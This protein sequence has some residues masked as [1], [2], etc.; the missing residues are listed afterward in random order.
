M[1]ALTA[2]E[3]EGRGRVLNE[4]RDWRLLYVL[5]GV[6]AFVALG[7]MLLDIGLAMV[8][9]WGTET[10]PSD[11]AAWF[12][13]FAS[14]PFLGMRNLD[15]LNVVLS[16][17]SLP[18]Y[19]ALYGAHRRS[20]PALATLGLLF[21]ALGTALF[22]TANAALPMLELSRAY[23]QEG[24]PATKAALAASAHALL[25]R[26]AHGSAGAFPGFFVSELGTLLVTLAM[27]RAEVFRRRVAWIGAVGTAVLIVYTIAYTFGGGE[28]SLVMAVAI[29]GGLLMI[30]WHA[31]VGSRLIAMGGESGQRGKTGTRTYEPADHAPRRADAR[32]SC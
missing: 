20:A 19:V 1:T 23:A 18:M 28:S 3:A 5:G 32:E 4:N 24:D 22:A 6:A 13:Q 15:L 9:G 27:L 10:V 2:L 30:A 14:R 29:P 8:P 26:G 25:S 12:A 7:G 21:V 31:M 17:L 16:I 11:V